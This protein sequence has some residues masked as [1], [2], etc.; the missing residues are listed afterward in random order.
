VQSDLK[1]RVWTK[2]SHATKEEREEHVPLSPQPIAAFEQLVKKRKNSPFVFPSQVN[3]ERP[4]RLV[5][6]VWMQALRKVGLVEQCTSP[7][8]A[9]RK[10]SIIGL[11]YGCTICITPT[12]PVW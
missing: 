2:P 6:Y 8:S 5:K 1:R 10:L 3:P 9:Q 7:G 12:H 4:L 11:P